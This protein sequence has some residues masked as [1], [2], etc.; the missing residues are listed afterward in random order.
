MKNNIVKGKIILI[1]SSLGEG[2]EDFFT[3]EMKERIFAINFFIVENERSARRFLRSIGYKNNFDEGTM[4][5]IAN[6]NEFVADKKI[7]DCILEGKNIGVLSEAGCPGI[8]D[9]GSAAIKW[10]HENNISVVPLIG[11]SSIFLALMASGFNGQ[12]FAFHGYLPIATEERKKKLKLLED[13]S[14]HRKQTQIFMETPYRN[15]SLLIDVLQVLKPSTLLCIAS[16]VSL[17]DEF[18]VTKKIVAWKKNIPDLKKK[19]TVF[20]VLAD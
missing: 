6:D 20:L 8:A 3:N 1:P 15:D 2:S 17:A 12:Q 18:I 14:L 16:N 9:P 13:E 4:I 5:G 7:M 11:P 10:A 19:P